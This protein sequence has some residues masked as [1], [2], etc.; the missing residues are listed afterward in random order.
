MMAG[1][2]GSNATRAPAREYHL[3]D[4]IPMQYAAWIG[5]AVQGDLSISLRTN[6][7]VVDLIAEETAGDIKLM[8]MSFA[9]LI[10]IPLGVL[11]AVKEIT[12]LDYPDE[13]PG[14]VGTLGAELPGSASC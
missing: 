9:L 1:E 10:G 4:P 8:S 14:A 12:F 3:N 2:A 6:Q 13:R 11:A 5:N 7:P